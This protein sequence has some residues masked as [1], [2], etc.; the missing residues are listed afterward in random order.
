MLWVKMYSFTVV[1]R[2]IFPKIPRNTPKPIICI[3]K[4]NRIFSI[5]LNNKFAENI[6]LRK[7]WPYLKFFCSAF[8]RIRVE[9]GDLQSKSTY[10][11]QMLE[12]ADQKNSG[13]SNFSRSAEQL[14]LMY[15]K[16]FTKLILLEHDRTYTKTCADQE[17]TQKWKLHYKNKRSLSTD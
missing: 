16:L 2:N 7:L 9:C 11:I 5:H 17:I 14:V 10:S 8:F 15:I 13:Y 6:S 4:W 12:N 3:L 1:Y